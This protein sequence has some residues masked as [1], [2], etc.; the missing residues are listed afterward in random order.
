M[1][2][3]GS[4]LSPN[5]KRVFGGAHSEEGRTCPLSTSWSP[6][7]LPRAPCPLR[8]LP[9]ERPP[10]HNR[11]HLVGA[12]AARAHGTREGGIPRAG[13]SSL[14]FTS[15]GDREGET[16]TTGVPSSTSS[17]MVAP[18]DV[19]PGHMMSAPLSTN[20]IAPRSTLSLFIIMGSGVVAPHTQAVVLKL[21]FG[22][23]RVGS[24]AERHGR[25][26]HDFAVDKRGRK[27]A[28]SVPPRRAGRMLA[29]GGAYID[30]AR[31]GGGSSCRHGRR[32]TAALSRSPPVGCDFGCIVAPRAASE[33]GRG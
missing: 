7:A 26:R 17:W 29:M 4:L 33:A 24:L 32:R 18:G 23:R 30:A 2:V 12:A 25:R 16:L 9:A 20:L 10:S 8:R 6:P 11:W 28:A 1:A 22:L 5:S 31:G 14:A 15:N 19:S 21:G 27:L 13:T 3:E